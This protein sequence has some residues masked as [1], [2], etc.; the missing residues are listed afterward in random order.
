MAIRIVVAHM[1]PL[2]SVAFRFLLASAILLPL[3]FFRR[4]RLP[5]GREWL[6]LFG[7][8]TLMMALPFSATAWAEQW[9]PSGKTSLLFA[10]APLVTGW[11]E[12]WL[13]R[14]SER[15]RL[16][17]TA[18]LGMLIALA[19]IV[20]VL[21]RTTSIARGE[22]RG[23]AAI[24]GVV[25]LGSA[26]TILSKQWLKNIPLLTLVAVETLFAGVTLGVASFFMEGDRPQAWT[27]SSV[28]AMLFLGLFSSALSFLLYYWLLMQIEPYQL[29]ARY[30]IT[31]IVAIAEGVVLLHEQ[32]TWNMAVG[33]LAVLAGLVLVLRSKTKEATDHRTPGSVRP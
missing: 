28:I 26:T 32:V 4:S 21:Y 19:G 23:V 5:K 31:P 24:L 13:G 12:T 17:F 30:F 11:M 3:M 10:M 16:P 22:G 18:I 9:I 8:G 7:L 27:E 20:V 6:L 15:R 1:P 2:R 25:V 14:P 29:A 33:A